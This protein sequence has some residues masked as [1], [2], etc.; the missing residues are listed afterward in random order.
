MAPKDDHVAEIVQLFDV[1]DNETQKF[2]KGLRDY[3][4]MAV[5]LKDDGTVTIY[6][7]DI[8]EKELTEIRETI[9]ETISERMGNADT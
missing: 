2:L 3:P 9:E 7:K 8:G 5:V 6:E 1:E 4:F